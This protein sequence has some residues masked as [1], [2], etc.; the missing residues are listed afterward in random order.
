MTT[1]F[2]LMTILFRLAI[3]TGKVTA[4]LLLDLSAASDTVDDSILLH[5]LSIGLVSLTLL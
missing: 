1:L 4:L 2:G 3:D 5:Q